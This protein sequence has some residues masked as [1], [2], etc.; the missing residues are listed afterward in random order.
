LEK[1]AEI[2]HHVIPADDLLDFADHQRVPLLDEP[3]PLLGARFKLYES[4]A[5]TAAN[6]G[7]DTVMTGD[8][9][10]HLFGQLPHT[11]IADL[12][13]RGQVRQAL[14]LVSQYSHFSS[15]SPWRIFGDALSLLLPPRLRDGIR[16]FLKG[17]RTDLRI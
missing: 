10:D 7:V 5:Q 11:V 12:M 9:A 4:L 3:S 15:Q 2:I 14:Q 13:S 16:P 8:G 6:A 17:G 1:S